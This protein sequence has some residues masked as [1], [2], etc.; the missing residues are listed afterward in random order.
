[1]NLSSEQPGSISPSRSRGYPAATL[2]FTE[3]SMQAAVFGRREL[4]GLGHL[5]DEELRRSLEKGFLAEQFALPESS[6][7]ALRQTHSDLSFRIDGSVPSGGIYFND[8]DALYTDREDTL[9]VVRTADCLPLFFFGRH[10]DP[11]VPRR[12]AGVIHAGWRGVHNEIIPRTLGK[13]AFEIFADEAHRVQWTFLIGPGIG[14][15]SYEVGEDVARHFRMV[16]PRPRQPGKFL[17]DLPAEA[18]LQLDRFHGEGKSVAWRILDDFRA[19]TFADNSLFYSHRKG[20][21][22]RNLNVILIRSGRNA[23]PGSATY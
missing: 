1:M 3:G 16:T 17:L 6:I 14:G 13:A 10:A 11:T 19:C 12:V 5:D 4:D 22:G 8:G 18:N 9:L 15:A 23:S 2:S 20:D 7:Y 21:R